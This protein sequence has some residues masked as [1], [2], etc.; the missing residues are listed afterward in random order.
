MLLIS[1]HAVSLRT[2]LLLQLSEI[3]SEIPFWNVPDVP[4]LAQGPQYHPVGS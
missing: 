4:H 2:R 3:Q 1:F